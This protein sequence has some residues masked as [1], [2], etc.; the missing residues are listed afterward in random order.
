MA[1]SVHAD[2]SA[3]RRS[4]KAALGFGACGQKSMLLS[5]LL[6]IGAN[7]ADSPKVL[8]RGER[9]ALLQKSY[10]CVRRPFPIDLLGRTDCQD[11]ACSLVSLAIR[12]MAMGDGQTFGVSPADTSWIER[13][14]ALDNRDGTTRDDGN[15]LVAIQVHGRES[16]FALSVDQQT[17][18]ITVR[19]DHYLQPMPGKPESR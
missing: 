10:P 19:E 13:A 6:V 12:R 8:T 17:G 15:W 5:V 14:S 16:S 7:C 2:R 18:R 3:S 9:M 1:G 4:K 11:E